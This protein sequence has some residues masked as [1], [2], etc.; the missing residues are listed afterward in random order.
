MRSGQRPLREAARWSAGA[1]R[2]PIEEI[3]RV[4][5]L[6]ME[7]LPHGVEPLLSV[8]G[9]YQPGIDT[10]VYLLRDARRPWSRSTRR[11]A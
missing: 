6:R 1:A 11:P 2:S 5:H 10:G 9:T 4:A 3:A 8:T 7:A